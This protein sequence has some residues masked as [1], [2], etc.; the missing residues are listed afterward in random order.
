[1][2]AKVTSAMKTKFSV[3]FLSGVNGNKC[4]YE[5]ETT[6]TP[7]SDSSYSNWKTDNS[8]AN[9]DEYLYSKTQFST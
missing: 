8:W 5:R 6:E 1:M 3:Y 9:E 4:K 2:A 7:L